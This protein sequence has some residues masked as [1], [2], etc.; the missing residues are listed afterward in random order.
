MQVTQIW[1][2]EK[3]LFTNHI[4]FFEIGSLKE[5]TKNIKTNNEF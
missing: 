2:G 1:I 5:S 4:I 3:F